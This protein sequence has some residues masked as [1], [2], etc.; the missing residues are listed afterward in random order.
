M[1]YI[2]AYEEGSIAGLAFLP[3]SACPYAQGTKRYHAWV[4]GW[5]SVLEALPLW[6]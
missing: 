6:A 1:S 2:L 5:M 3:K 4:N